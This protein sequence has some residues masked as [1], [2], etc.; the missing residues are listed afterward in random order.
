MDY[1]ETITGL[2]YL[3]ICADGTVNEKE[4]Q[5]GK[6]MIIAEGFDEQK[7]EAS[8][9]GLKTR[10]KESVYKDCITGLK[11]LDKNKQIRSISW[12]CVIANSDGFMDKKEWMLIYKIYGSE[13]G[14]SLDDILRTQKELTKTLHKNEFLSFGTIA[15]DKK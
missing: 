12:L 15:E 3:L 6:K 4:L 7:F 11:K 14:L 9:N 10:D 2:Y 13:L 1:R 8:I 5:L